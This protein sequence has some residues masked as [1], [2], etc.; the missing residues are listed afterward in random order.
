APV[1][2][3]TLTKRYTLGI[4]PATVRNELMGLEE[5]GYVRSPHVSAGRVPT[6]TGYRSFVNSLLLSEDVVADGEIH[7]LRA[8]LTRGYRGVSVSM[9]TL[10]ESLIEASQRIADYTQCLSLIWVPYVSGF[11]FYR[12]MPL[13]LAQPEFRDAN[14]AIPLVRLLE[15]TGGLVRVLMGSSEG[16]R[17][18][19]RIGSENA[20]TDLRSFSVVASGFGRPQAQG[21]VAV[22]GPTRLDYRKA[23]KA[24]WHASRALATAAN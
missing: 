19:V 13:L 16:G 10:R 7:A 6:I 24:V 17:L 14:T 5:G 8:A 1:G 3:S 23:I 12:G 2:S 9:E 21:V 20:E 4:S 18:Y 22:F 15:D 11:V